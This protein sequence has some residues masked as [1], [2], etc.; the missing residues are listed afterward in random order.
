MHERPDICLVSPPT[1][2]SSA[3]VPAALLYLHAW[4]VKSRIA[5]RIVDIKMGYPGVPA[6]Q[7][8][9][10]RAREAIVS[11]ILVLKPKFI[12]IP[13]YS[14]EFGEVMALSRKIK[15]VHPCII[16][17]G[18]LHASIKPE[19]FF[20]KGSP[21]DYAVS[22]DGQQ[23]L[24]K[25]ISCVTSGKP[26][27]GVEGL[28]HSNGNDGIVK[29]RD[30]VFS[31]WESLPVPDYSQ[32]DMDY[33][34]K[35]NVGIIRN[36]FTSGIH[37]FTTIGCPFLCTFCANRSRT[38]RFRPFEKVFEELEVLKRDYKIDA[39][40]I[41]D[42][43]FMIKKSR[44][45]E[46]VAGL[47]E[48]K[49]DLI[50]AMETR[51]NLIDDE[52]AEL[53]RDAG[54]LQVDFGVESGSQAALDRMKK[55]ITVEEAISA[56]EICKRHNLRSLVNLMFNTPGETEEDVRMTMK[57]MRKITPT[58]LSLCLTVPFP[59]TVI[60][61]QYVNPPLTKEEYN[62][63]NISFLYDKIV[64]KRFYMAK[65]RLDIV[66]LRFTET[67]RV[68]GLRSIIDG[69]LN[70]RYWRSLILSK[71]KAQYVRIIFSDF[72]MLTLVR[73]ARVVKTCTRSR[74][75]KSA[76]TFAN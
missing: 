41:L 63:Y 51:V 43:T 47:K 26:V 65:H 52:I 58:R 60:Y 19:D 69:T 49:I 75:E 61:D 70:P 35:P 12:G 15:S 76:G 33:Y 2:T 48:R 68:N 32:L 17:I 23:P 30:A 46:F 25:I 20:Y 13:C 31:E 18:G 71:R 59:G 44:V 10:E 36:L 1:R 7:I 73:I 42:D 27:T 74:K 55:G 8:Q 50:W 64:D 62:I 40:Y 22:G 14:T 34:T 45:R 9:K 16:I 11:R 24:V 53:L 57:M 3:T 37:I 72:M 6:T 66:N 28:I 54:C 29:N 38:V 39:F 21:I 4:L 56:V 67:A 5:C